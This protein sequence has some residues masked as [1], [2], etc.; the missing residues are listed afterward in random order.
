MG[1]VTVL[2][3][4]YTALIAKGS[5]K[6]ILYVVVMIF[7]LGSIVIAYLGKIEQMGEETHK[8][9]GVVT[10]KSIVSSTATADNILPLPYQMQD[11]QVIPLQ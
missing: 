10:Y 1:T 3:C 8:Q 6:I 5:N 2:I 7:I 9:D 11:L 4:T